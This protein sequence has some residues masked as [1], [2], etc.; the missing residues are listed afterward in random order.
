MES[1]KIFLDNSMKIDGLKFYTSIS[2]PIRKSLQKDLCVTQKRSKFKY[3]FH[4]F[5][6]IF[7]EILLIFGYF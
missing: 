1:I 3:I 6:T 5:L 7:G 4:V 2:D